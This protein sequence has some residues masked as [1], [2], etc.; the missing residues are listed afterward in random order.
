MSP[1]PAIYGHN[2]IVQSNQ[3]QQSTE[4]NNNILK[5]FQDVALNELR[6][7][8]NTQEQSLKQFRNILLNNPDI[9]NLRIDDNFLLRFLRVKKYNISL[10]EQVLLKYLNLRK[11]YPHMCTQLDILDVNQNSI[12]SNGYIFVSPNRDKSG[13]RIVFVNAKLFN[14]KLYSSA[15]QAKAHI[16]T[17]ETLL[18]DPINQVIGL[19][20]IGDLSGI[21]ASLVLN[22]NPTEFARILRWG[23]QSLPIRHKAVHLVNVPMPFKW[24]LDFVKGRVSQKM[25]QRFHAYTNIKEL[26]K[27]VDVECLPKEMGGIM[28]MKEMIELWKKEL[29]ARRESVIALDK[30]RL[31]S[32]RGI[33]T[34]RNRNNVTIN[35][36]NDI[37]KN[38]KVDHKLIGNFKKLELD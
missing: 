27:N 21:T 36:I 24:V 29:L 34:S 5:I 11:T 9:Q 4:I 2:T 19:T 8:K 18:E 10:S 31:T 37:K 3:F 28:P 12:I 30:M 33:I 14:A 1:T 13:R 16:L 35:N 23:E 25:K 26:R 32:D 15:D 17:Y 7:D 38:E 20:H 22:W 6:E